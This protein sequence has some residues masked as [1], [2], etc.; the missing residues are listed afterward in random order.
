M[1]ASTQYGNSSST[2]QSDARTIV[3]FQTDT[4]ASRCVSLS[5]SI[6]I[7]FLRTHLKV[8]QRIC[9]VRAAYIYT[10]KNAYIWKKDGPAAASKRRRQLATGTWATC[11]PARPRRAT[12]D[13]PSGFCPSPPHA[14]L[15]VVT[16][17]MVQGKGK[18]AVVE[19]LSGP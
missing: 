3:H 2:M 19:W 10:K 18:A 8:H 13:P 5:D 16:R 17:A 1:V 9:F 7:S 15:S 12:V 14:A 11:P 6:Y 4:V